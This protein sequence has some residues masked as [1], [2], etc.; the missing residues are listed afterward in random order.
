MGVLMPGEK[1]RCR[2]QI[3]KALVQRAHTAGLLFRKSLF[4]YHLYEA[5]NEKYG[6][7]L[8]ARSGLRFIIK[9]DTVKLQHTVASPNTRVPQD[10]STHAK[11]SMSLQKASEW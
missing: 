11:E 2:Q 1:F 7:E 10:L 8:H 3:L 5:W 6:Y 4:L 9:N